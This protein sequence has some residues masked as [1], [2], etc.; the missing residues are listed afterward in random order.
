MYVKMVDFFSDRQF[1]SLSKALDSKM[2]SLKKA[3]HGIS[4][5]ADVIT[6]SEEEILWKKGLLGAQSPDV[7]GDT[8]VYMCGLFLHSV[9]G[10]N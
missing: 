2:K 6:D 10:P 7:L 4:K 1:T 5:Q 3:G 8:M 9:V